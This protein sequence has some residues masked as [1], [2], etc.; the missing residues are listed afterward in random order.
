MGIDYFNDEDE[1]LPFEEEEPLD[2]NEDDFLSY[3][4]WYRDH[5]GDRDR[6]LDR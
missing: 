6:R 1:G 2:P 5:E 3:E 4:D